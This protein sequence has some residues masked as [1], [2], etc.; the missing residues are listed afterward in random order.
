M[1]SIEG[2]DEDPLFRAHVAQL[3]SPCGVFREREITGSDLILHRVQHA[4]FQRRIHRIGVFYIHESKQKPIIS[5]KDEG[6]GQLIKSGDIFFRYAGRTQRI[7]FPELNYIIEQRVKGTNDQWI[8]LM[9]KI[10]KAGPAN[11]AILDTERGIIEKSENQILVIDEDLI[12]KIKF[13]KEGQFREDKGATTL[14]LVGDVKPIGALEVT[15]TIQKRLTDQYPLSWAQVIQNV[16]SRVTDANINTI[17]QII[18]DNDLKNK[19]QYSDY[20]FR[21]KSQEDEHKKTGKL[22]KGITSIYNENAV[23]FIIQ[24]LKKT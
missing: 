18:K 14:R 15:R 9:G 20:N 16:K 8:A 22:P 4:L 5:K 19:T 11:A 3:I 23:N 12:N 13:I 6:R 2:G 21:T 1:S 24:T 10:A 7:E 17:N